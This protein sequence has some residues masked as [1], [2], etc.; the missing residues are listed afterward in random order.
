MQTGDLNAESLIR[1]GIL[2]FD[3]RRNVVH[4][5]LR[6]IETNAV[7]QTWGGSQAMIILVNIWGVKARG[8]QSSETSG[9]LKPRGITPTTVRDRLLIMM[10]RPTMFGSAPKLRCHRSYPRITTPSWSGRSSSAV[11]VRPSI[12]C[13]R[14]TSKS[15]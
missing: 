9:N 10:F 4:F 12:G 2:L 6:L 14:S 7:F 8:I 5:G 3:A 15:P 13:T 11:N 1:H